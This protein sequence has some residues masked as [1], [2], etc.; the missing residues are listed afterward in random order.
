MTVTINMPQMAANGLSEN[1]LFKFCGDLHWQALCTSLGTRSAD[2][3][4]EAGARLYPT[5]VAIKARYSGPL[6]GVCENDKF[7]TT[8]QLSHFGKPFFHGL[9]KLFNQASAFELEMLTTFVSRQSEGRNDLL[10]G[11]PAA[12][13]AYT[14]E[15]L[16]DAPD[17][18]KMSQRM[19]HGE[20]ERYA[21]NGCDLDLVSPPLDLR[22]EYEPSP[23]ADFNGA[24]LL[25][26]AAYPTICDT[27]ERRMIMDASLTLDERDWALATS[28]IAR[29]VYYYANLDIGVRLK[30]R[31]NALIPRDETIFQ[32]TTLLRAPDDQPIADLFT[33]RKVLD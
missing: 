8:A 21:F 16:A 30:A 31:L 25:Y 13:F 9:V 33:A 32:H 14:S 28:T 11:S 20:L 10:K 24:N 2:L 17:I 3:R 29:D 1:W 15:G 19:R 12:S 26:F 27:L 18:L 5:F 4:D 23:Y 7:E 6:S 22:C